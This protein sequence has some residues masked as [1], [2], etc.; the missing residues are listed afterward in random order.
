MIDPHTLRSMRTP[1]HRASQDCAWRPFFSSC[2]VVEYSGVVSVETPPSPLLPAWRDS[3]EA[4]SRGAGRTAVYPH[5]EL[6]WGQVDPCC[7]VG[8]RPATGWSCC[9]GP[10]PAGAAEFGFSDSAEPESVGADIPDAALGRTSAARFRWRISSTCQPSTT[11]NR[12]WPV[13]RSRKV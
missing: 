1:C 2:V 5:L 6:F 7:C 3:H 12:S 9:H 13:T 11:N 4:S 10:L 8:R